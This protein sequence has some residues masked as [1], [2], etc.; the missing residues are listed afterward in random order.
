MKFLK[1]W[2]IQDGGRVR[3]PQFNMMEVAEVSQL[4]LQW[5]LS[6]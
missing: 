1:I 5:L 3:G 6:S 2:S 4:L